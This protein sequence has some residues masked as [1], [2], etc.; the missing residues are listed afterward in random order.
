M[1]SELSELFDQICNG[2]LV[3]SHAEGNK[4]SLGMTIDD[5]LFG[6]SVILLKQSLLSLE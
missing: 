1:R 5:S 3:V 6:M 4:S 2:F